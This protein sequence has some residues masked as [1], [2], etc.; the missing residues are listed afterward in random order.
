MFGKGSF[1]IACE[2]KVRGTTF[3]A[4]GASAVALYVRIPYCAVPGLKFHVVSV[5]RSKID[6][7]FFPFSPYHEACVCVYGQSSTV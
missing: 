7:G 4:H 6:L 2:A 5:D 1:K 3:A